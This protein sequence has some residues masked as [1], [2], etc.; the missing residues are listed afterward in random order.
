MDRERSV[1]SFLIFVLQQTL[2]YIDTA[3]SLFFLCVKYVYYLTLKTESFIWSWMFELKF[4][5]QITG[6][7]KDNFLISSMVS[8]GHTIHLSLLLSQNSFKKSYF[9]FFNISVWCPNF[10]F[11]VKDV[12][13]GM[14]KISPFPLFGNSHEYIVE[15]SFRCCPGWVWS[16]IG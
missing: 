7:F 4:S 16:W 10:C 15:P 2:A 9:W 13:F 12:L 8:S 11:L 14:A 1:C 6:N 3:V 5:F